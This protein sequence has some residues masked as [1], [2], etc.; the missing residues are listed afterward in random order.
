MAQLTCWHDT[1][2]PRSSGAKSDA[3]GRNRRRLVVSWR[4]AQNVKR[5]EAVYSEAAEYYVDR[6]AEIFAYAR[7]PFLT[8]RGDVKSWARALTPAGRVR[9]DG[10]RGCGLRETVRGYSSTSM[11]E[12]SRSCLRRPQGKSACRQSAWSGLMWPE[13]LRGPAGYGTGQATLGLPR[14]R[15]GQLSLATTLNLAMKQK[16]LLEVDHYR[17]FRPATE[18]RSSS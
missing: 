5:Q 11:R 9:R 16:T 10:R 18:T 7:D 13:E 6:A 4:N 3:N 12:P 1:M 15:W 8:P 17:L 2:S 14:S